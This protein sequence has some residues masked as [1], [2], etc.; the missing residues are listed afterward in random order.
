MNAKKL[1]LVLLAVFGVLLV[2]GLVA[3][4]NGIHFLGAQSPSKDRLS[5]LDFFLFDQPRTLSPVILST[6]E[7]K[8][9]ALANTTEQWQLVNFGYMFC[10]DICPINLRL[11]SEVKREWDAEK[12]AADFAITHITFDP[13]RDTPD[14]LSKYLEYI[15]KNYIGLT[16][17]LEEIRK[18]AQQL[19]TIFI[20]EKPDEYG[21]Y[22]ITHS[23]S[24]A[25]LNPQGQYV[26]LFKGPYD[27][28]NMVKA[29]EYLIN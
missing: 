8:D 17:D 7:G 24:I 1:T 26:G 2:L 3:K 11:M 23:D 4:Q 25:L 20:H 12:K 16:G 9:T 14:R 18:V 22:F 5:Q 10:P 21:N 28:G 6:L 15:D 13:E 29:L 19:N 27:K